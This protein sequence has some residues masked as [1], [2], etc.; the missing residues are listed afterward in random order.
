MQVQ[1]RRTRRS[2]HRAI[3]AAL[4]AIAA[5]LVLQMSSALGAPQSQLW[6]GQA[7]GPTPDIE[8]TDLLFYLP[9]GAQGPGG[10]AGTI[11]LTLDGV[12][13]VAYCIE[14]TKFLNQNNPGP[15]A[16]VTEI[17]LATPADRAVLWILQNRTPT[18]PVTPA[19]QDEAATAQVAVWV[20]RGELRATNPTSSASINAA[21]AALV[22]EAL[23]ESATPRTI[24]LSTAPPAPGAT[25]ATIT[26]AAKPGSVVQLAVTSGPGTLSAPSV[27]VG[28][29]G[30]ATVT[31]TGSGPGTTTVS[32][33]T[34]GDGILYAIQ[35]TSDDSQNTTTSGKGNIS[36]STS[37]TFAAVS[38]TVTPVAPVT[39]ATPVAPSGT[40][41]AKA[42]LA[43]TKTAPRT[44]KVLTRVRYTI[45]VKNTSKVTAK[46]VTLRDTLP[47]GLSFAKSS[48]LGRL[49]TGRISFTLGTLKAGESRT[50]SVWLV[51]NASVRG[52][53]TNTATAQAT[54]VAAVRANAVT[55]FAPI[56]KRIQPAVTG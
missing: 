47:S 7:N 9:N 1:P 19:K 17:P 26:I 12:P 22:A 49:A 18:G 30:T 39:P 21:A 45:V 44:A 5:L 24:A 43:I 8:R 32:G 51:A 2:A 36:A 11:N 55:V 34:A 40:I 37:V 33:T 41:T 13:V 16:D 54:G 14:T 50:V 23:A 42:K 48:R 46:N 6:T 10:A 38:G 35:P 53:R 29:S 3:A 28:P 56:A 31:L 27:T 4:A 20:L 15:T 52:K 25:S